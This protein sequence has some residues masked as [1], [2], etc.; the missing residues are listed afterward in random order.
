M[1]VCA[2]GESEREVERERDKDGLDEQQDRKLDQ[3]KTTRPFCTQA[4]ERVCVCVIC[5]S[6]LD[7][8]YL[9]Q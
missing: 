2:R 6:I 4:R 8:I 1:W 9:S 7:K 5:T 3:D